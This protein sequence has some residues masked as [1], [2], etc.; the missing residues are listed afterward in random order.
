MKINIK[1]SKL[2]ATAGIAQYAEKKFETLSKFTKKFEEESSALLDVTIGKTT[3]HHQKGDVFQ[4]KASIELLGR[5]LLAEEESQDLYAAIDAA[6]DTLK[7][8]IEKFK[9]KHKRD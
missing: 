2:D 6:K 8:E 5:L 4:V 9:E 7:I 3:R 1:Y